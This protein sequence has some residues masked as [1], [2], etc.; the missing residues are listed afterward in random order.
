MLMY[1]RNQ[2]NI[3]KQLSSNKKKKF[4]FV[5]VHKSYKKNISQ[6]LNFLGFYDFCFLFLIYFWNFFS[7]CVFMT[8]KVKTDIEMVSILKFADPNRSGINGLVRELGTGAV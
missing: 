1:G 5:R 2:H 7:H 3:L 8:I 4:K 6:V